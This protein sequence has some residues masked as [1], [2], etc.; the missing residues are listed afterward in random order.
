ML[1]QF[2]RQDLIKAAL[3]LCSGY[4]SDSTFHT[5]RIFETAAIFIELIVQPTKLPVYANLTTQEA[6]LQYVKDFMI[7][8]LVKAN[9]SKTSVDSYE[10]LCLLVHPSFVASGRTDVED[11]KHVMRFFDTRTDAQLPALRSTILSHLAMI[12]NAFKDLRKAFES[13]PEFNQDA[14]DEACNQFLKELEAQAVK[15]SEDGS[16]PPLKQNELVTEEVSS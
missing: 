2:M 14:W 12:Y 3:A 11:N 4:E 10:V 9:L 15:M 8:K 16:I 13:D 6:R 1:Y 7:F 5:R